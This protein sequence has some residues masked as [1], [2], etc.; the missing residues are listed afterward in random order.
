M[1]SKSMLPVRASLDLGGGPG[2]TRGLSMFD[3]A[4]L[5]RPALPLVKSMPEAALLNA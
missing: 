3:F 4:P 1:K 2:A 5:T